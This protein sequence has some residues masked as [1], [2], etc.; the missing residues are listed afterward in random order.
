MPATSPVGGGLGRER[1]GRR[2]RRAERDEDDAHRDVQ[3]GEHRDG[4]VGERSPGAPCERGGVGRRHAASR[5]S[6]SSAAHGSPFASLQRSLA[7]RRVADRV[8]RREP[9]DERGVPALED[10]AAA[11]PVGPVG[12]AVAAADHRQVRDQLDLAGAQPARFAQDLEV[13]AL[14]VEEQLHRALAQQRLA[15]RAG[16]EIVE[17]LGD[18]DQRQAEVA[19]AAR[20]VGDPAAGDVVVDQRPRLLEDEERAAEDDVRRAAR[21][22]CAPAWRRAIPAATCS[23]IRIHH[24]GDELRETSRVSKTTSGASEVDR[25]LAVQQM[26]VRALG[27]E[28]P[29]APREIVGDLGVALGAALALGLG[30][31]GQRGVQIALAGDAAAAATGGA[32]DRRSRSAS[33]ST[34]RS[35]SVSP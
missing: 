20:H 1:S 35:R 32:A 11:G 6:M 27:G 13:V 33:S 14:L 5:A 22:R 26:R 8:R 21:P 30:A 15:V 25:R 2:A 17:L 7:S 12:L 3:H 16:G 19:R 23:P 4:R 31:V 28:P 18:G 29:H 10:G 9:V 34:I 24:A